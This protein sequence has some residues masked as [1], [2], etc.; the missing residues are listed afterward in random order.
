MDEHYPG[1]D[2]R[3][4][5]LPALVR[6]GG[7]ANGARVVPPARP[8]AGRRL[9]TPMTGRRAADTDALSVEEA[10]ARRE[11][12]R[13]P[14]PAST[15]VSATVASPATRA[16][17]IAEVFAADA[18]MAYNQIAAPNRARATPPPCQEVWAARILALDDLRPRSIGD[19]AASQ[20]DGGDPR[21]YTECRHREGRA[22]CCA[23]A[24]TPVSGQRTSRHRRQWC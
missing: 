10:M 2:I 8:D 20:G 22:R 9:P 16:T 15:T 19:P 13:A 23:S 18:A 24:R 21:R 12:N 7:V 5:R 6:G 11:A 3:P 17:P 14:P 1:G 4:H